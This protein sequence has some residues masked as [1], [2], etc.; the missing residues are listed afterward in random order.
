ML[1]SIKPLLIQFDNPVPIRDTR[2]ASRGACVFTYI[3]SAYGYVA[4]YL[5]QAFTDVIGSNTEIHTVAVMA[6]SIHPFYAGTPISYLP[7]VK[8]GQQAVTFIANCGITET[9]P[10]VSLTKIMRPMYNTMVGP[11]SPVLYVVQGI[12]GSSVVTLSK[13]DDKSLAFLQWFFSNTGQQYIDKALGYSVMFSVAYSFANVPDS[14][15]FLN[16][17]PDSIQ[18]NTIGCEPGTVSISFAI[19]SIQQP[20]TN[21]SPILSTS[22]TLVSRSA[23]GL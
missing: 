12:E 10:N 5:M 11:D 13:W 7:V 1:Q 18:Q 6:N 8:P 23:F 20:I 3:V 14:Y 17:I 15:L 22:Y 9:Q 19:R 2:I 4:Q 21:A 16:C